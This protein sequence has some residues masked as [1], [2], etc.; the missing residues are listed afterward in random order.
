MPGPQLK[1]VLQHFALP[2]LTAVGFPVP[3]AVC[4][5]RSKP[6]IKLALAPRLSLAA[7]ECHPLAAVIAGVK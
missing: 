5:L 1:A 6:S 3:K 7:C 2:A 4:G